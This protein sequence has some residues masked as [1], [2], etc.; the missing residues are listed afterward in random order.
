M[1]LYHFLLLFVIKKQSVVLPGW[2]QVF[3]KVNVL[4]VWM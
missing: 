2:T 1:V 3:G 4:P